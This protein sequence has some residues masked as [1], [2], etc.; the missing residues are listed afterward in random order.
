MP[1][2]PFSRSQRRHAAESI[3]ACRRGGA[4]AREPATATNACR[5]GETLPEADLVCRRGEAGPVGG[6]AGYL[7]AGYLLADRARPCR[8]L[9][10]GDEGLP[11]RRG[12]MSEAMPVC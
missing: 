2:C 3:L 1:V 4:G 5:R 9:S 11:E 10:G 6:D 8:P 12:A 7:L